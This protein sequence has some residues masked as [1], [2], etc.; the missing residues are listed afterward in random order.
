MTITN[1]HKEDGVII[2]TIENDIRILLDN[3]VDN[4]RLLSIWEKKSLQTAFNLK[5]SSISKRFQ[6][7]ALDAMDYG[8]EDDYD[9]DLREREH[10]EK[11]HLDVEPLE[12]YEEK[13]E[14]LGDLPVLKELNKQFQKYFK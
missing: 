14:T 11:D 13:P 7:D 12:G 10:L 9:E 5:K 1:M 8:E 3:H 4:R 2:M 6:E